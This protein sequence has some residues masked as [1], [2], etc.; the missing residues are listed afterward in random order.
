[1]K[2]LI[3][4]PARDILH[5]PGDNDTHD[6]HQQRMFLVRVDQECIRCAAENVDR[7]PRAEGRPSFGPLSCVDLVEQKLVD[8]AEDAA[9]HHD[10]YQ[11]IYELDGIPAGFLFKKAHDN[12]SLSGCACEYTAD[13]PAGLRSVHPGYLYY[14]KKSAGKQF[15]DTFL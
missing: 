10:E 2:E 5:D 12:S 8:K 3:Q 7:D 13:V 6:E 15:P 1:M 14:N 9:A 4:D 11:K